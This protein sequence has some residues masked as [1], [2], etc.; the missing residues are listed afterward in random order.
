MI[1]C[2]FDSLMGPANLGAVCGKRIAPRQH[3]E[4]LILSLYIS[5]LTIYHPSISFHIL[6][7]F[8]TDCKHRY[9]RRGHLR[10]VYRPTSFVLHQKRHP[11]PF[12]AFCEDLKGETLSGHTATY[13][14]FR[15]PG[16]IL[17]DHNGVVKLMCVE[18]LYNILNSIIMEYI[19]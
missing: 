6:K 2:A 9:E 13:S 4:S 8:H 16:T 19:S 11:S 7:T 5:Y 14:D 17:R 1:S 3:L 15:F 10:I 18:T 12:H